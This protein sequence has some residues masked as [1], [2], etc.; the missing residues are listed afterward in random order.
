MDVLIKILLSLYILLVFIYDGTSLIYIVGLSLVMVIIIPKIYKTRKIKLNTTI[1]LMGIFL[2]F[3]LGTVL[4]SIDQNVALIRVISLLFNVIVLIGIIN[5]VDNKEKIDFI[6]KVLIYSGLLLGIILIINADISNN[7]RLGTDVGSINRMGIMLAFSFILTVYYLLKERKYLYL[8]Y[9]IFLLVIILLLG[10]R[11]TL[12]FIVFSLLMSYLFYTKLNIIKIGK[13]IISSVVGLT[14]L[15]FITTRIEAFQFIERRFTN[16]FYFL[17][18]DNVMEGSINAR[19]NMI[20]IGIDFFLQRPLFGYGID[21][22]QTLYQLT[23]GVMRYSHNNYI[24]LLVGIGIT[25]TLLYY[26]IY[27]KELGSLIVCKRPI[28]PLLKNIYTGIIFATFLIGISTVYYSIKISFIII[29]LISTYNA[30][31]IKKV[32]YH[33]TTK[34]GVLLKN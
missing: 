1:I 23:Y 21:N 27:F 26:S 28:D 2:T 29:A 3:S 9:S 17:L 11:Q 10:S 4:Y 31:N 14:I 16:L 18:E 5:Y 7:Y 24:E 25:G 33:N 15:Y 34:D 20:N 6:Q 19:S 13:M 22:Y 32:E 12:I 8:V 30:L